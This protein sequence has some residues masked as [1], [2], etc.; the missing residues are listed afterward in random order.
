MTE[1]RN[2]TD[3]CETITEP[4]KQQNECNVITQMSEKPHAWEIITEP[5]EYGI[6]NKTSVK[7]NECELIT[8]PSGCETNE[9]IYNCARDKYSFHDQLVCIV[10]KYVPIQPSNKEYFEPKGSLGKE[11]KNESKTNCFKKNV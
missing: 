4:G 11:T 6:I 10:T 1:I 9:K 5:Y 8:E 2:N 3:K 7:P